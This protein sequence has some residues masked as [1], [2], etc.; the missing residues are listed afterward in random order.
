MFLEYLGLHKIKQHPPVTTNRTLSLVLLW[1]ARSPKSPVSISAKQ[2]SFGE[3]KFSGSS[4]PFSHLAQMFDPFVGSSCPC[5]TPVQQN[6]IPKNEPVAARSSKRFQTYHTALFIG[7]NLFVFRL[8]AW[9]L[10]WGH[11]LNLTDQV[12][13][14]ICFSNV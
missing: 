10:T 1:V 3:G 8:R 12:C 13:C 7:W 4:D 5:W 14:L 11:K 2:Y 9:I 6:K